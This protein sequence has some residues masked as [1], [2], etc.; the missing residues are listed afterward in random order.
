MSYV[1]I[2][3]G[4][5]VTARKPHVCDWCARE[6]V[7]GEKYETWFGLSDGDPYRGKMHPECVQAAQRSE[8]DGE[9]CNAMYPHERGENCTECA[10]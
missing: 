6:I 4:K 7:I 3:Y 1:A 5:V 9:Y 8:Y 2:D 10:L